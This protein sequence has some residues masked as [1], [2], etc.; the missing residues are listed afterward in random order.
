L[1]L[2]LMLFLTAPLRADL[3]TPGNVLISTEN[4]SAPANM[5][6]E[7]T[8]GGTQV[9]GF[10]VPYPGGRPATEDVRDIATDLAGHV[11]IYNGTFSPFLTTLTPTA[12][13]GAGTY[14]HN[15]TAGFSSVA[16]VSFGGTATLG[17]FAYLS[18]MA[19]A[20]PGGPN[21]IVRFDLVTCTN[22]RFGAGNDYG[23]VTVGGDGLLYANRNPG[24]GVN[25]SSIDV[26][27]PAT[28]ALVRTI[29]LSAALST[30]DV[31]GI[32]VDSAGLLYAAAWD[33]NIYQVSST[34]SVLNS[35]PS[36][37]SNLTDI[38][39]DNTGRLIVGGRFGNVILTTTSLASQTSFLVGGNPVHVAFVTPLAVPEP[40]T[41]GLM[42]L[43]LCALASRCRRTLPESWF[44]GKMGA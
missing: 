1:S 41:G 24:G 23:D 19:T 25:A 11:Q 9:Q 13:P 18:D 8:A 39:L 31:R 34:G 37:T 33:G 14:V 4:F 10:S 35:R 30:A 7:Y 36:G 28:T 40:A 12:G 26:Y 20:S 32:A 16:N 38:D 43:G 21:G 27:N 15:T 6:F 5:V 3:L 29:S 44:S 22:T 2:L 17:N 42:M